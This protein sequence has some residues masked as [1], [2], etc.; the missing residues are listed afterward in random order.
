MINDMDRE[1]YLTASAKAFW[2][3]GHMDPQQSAL[4]GDLVRSGTSHAL[5]EDTVGLADAETRK[6]ILAC[7]LKQISN[8]R[9]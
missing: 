5:W 3:I 6:T 9:K 7:L 4:L 1:I 8:P 2:E